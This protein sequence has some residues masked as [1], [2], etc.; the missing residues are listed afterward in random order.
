M[1]WYGPTNWYTWTS[2][3]TSTIKPGSV[4]WAYSLYE[5]HKTF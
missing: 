5:S 1:L 3:K 2:F 4:Y